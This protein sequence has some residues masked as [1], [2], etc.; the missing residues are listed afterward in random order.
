MEY[1][2]CTEQ[3]IKDSVEKVYLEFQK[4][5]NNKKDSLTIR[6]YFIFQLKDVQCYLNLLILD[7][8]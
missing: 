3:E 4:A 5:L 2:E 8:G 6:Y 7:L 1:E